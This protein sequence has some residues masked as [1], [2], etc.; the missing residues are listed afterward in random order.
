LAGCNLLRIQP[1]DNS[2]PY[3]QGV[4]DIFISFSSQF[5]A[6]LHMALLSTCIITMHHI[7][8]DRLYTAIVFS[9]SFWRSKKIN[10]GLKMIRL[11]CLEDLFM[12]ASPLLHDCLNAKYSARSV[13]PYWCTIVY[14]YNDWRGKQLRRRFRM[15]RNVKHR[16]FVMYWNI[17]GLPTAYSEIWVVIKWFWM[18]RIKCVCRVAGVYVTR[19]WIERTLL[20][21]CY[22]I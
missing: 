5:L 20:K 15:T 1:S 11:L 21:R 6:A 10:F 7:C 8:K 13:G 3:F 17:R 19:A 14:V 4:A 2:T 18:T 9:T 16:H 12:H 22:F